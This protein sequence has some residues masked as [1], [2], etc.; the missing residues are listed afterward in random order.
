MATNERSPHSTPPDK[1]PS[2]GPSLWMMLLI[3]LFSLTIITST[4]GDPGMA[5]DEGITIRRQE[6]IRAWIAEL[7][8]PNQL[9]DRLSALH[10]KQILD[11]LR[12]QSTSPYKPLSSYWP[13][14]RVIEGHPPFYGI[15]GVIGW[16]LS[17]HWLPPLEAHRFGPAL[18]FSI[19]VGALY[20]ATATLFG[21]F[22]GLTTAVCCLFLPRLFAHAHLA[23][24]DAPVSCFWALSWVFFISARNHRY[25]RFLFGVMLGLS[26]ATKFT[27]WLAPLPFIM[28]CLLYRDTK[29]IHAMLVGIPTALVTFYVF[30][31]PLWHHPVVGITDFLHLNLH[32][33]QTDSL[34]IST[35]FLGGFYDLQRPIP[36]F[37]TLLWLLITTP[38]F[39]GILSLLGL[40]HF[41][42]DRCRNHHIA[43]VI[44]HWAFLM[45]LRAVP[46]APPH[47]GIR[48]FLPSFI[49]LSVL[50][51]IGVTSILSR[52]KTL[53]VTSCKRPR[54][55]TLTKT[56]LACSFM[57][58]GFSTWFYHPHQLSYYNIC[59]GGLPGAVRLGMEP[60]YY[61]DSLTNDVLTWLNDHSN[62]ADTV[63]FSSEQDSWTYLNR[64][65]QDHR[66]KGAKLQPRVARPP[67]P[68]KV[69]WYV[70]QLRPSSY[71]PVD[72]VLLDDPVQYPPKYVKTIHE[73]PLKNMGAFCLDVPIIHIYSYSQYHEALSASRRSKP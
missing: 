63:L 48:L 61:W 22:A 64:W 47:D 40:L 46:G 67:D 55:G 15:V 32:R 14:T 50:S 42:L 43:L 29:G 54:V 36:W 66:S 33:D 27:G 58:S 53:D 65:P 70:L 5:W 25:A 39:T 2:S 69:A 35:L 16:G 3:I 51:G 57:G 26:M 19:T 31:P 8:Q 59:I 10:D 72:Q 6:R 18:L 20:W 23:S 68:G 73:Q 30:N 56:V 49:F 62:P 1:Q 71:R 11:T 7:W 45:I 60:T 52:M 28:W 24:Y 38:L 13:Y 21:S 4:L 41:F 44:L 17:Q 34:N 37:N 12:D 9:P